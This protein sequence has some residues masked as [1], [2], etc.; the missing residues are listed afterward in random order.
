LK[1]CLVVGCADCVRA[2]VKAAQDLCD[3]DA[4]YCVKQAGIHWPNKFDVWA[5]LHPEYMRG[6]NDRVPRLNYVAEREALGYP[7]GYEIVVPLDSEVGRHSGKCKDARRA[8]Y[9]WPGMSSSASSGIYAVKV[10]LD[11]GFDRVVIAGCPMTPESGHFLPNTK[12]VNGESRGPIWKQ[13]DNFK[14][15]LLIAVPFMR[16][17][18]KSMSGY[19]KEL[20]G[21][22]TEAW[23]SGR[24]D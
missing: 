24:T 13:R 21:Y 15:G 16:G 6:E 2:D 19:T 4:V 5:G 20:L 11:D 10:A 12:N 7:G 17:K 9:R 23:L 22:P 14:P 3:F 8:S 18:V 1:T